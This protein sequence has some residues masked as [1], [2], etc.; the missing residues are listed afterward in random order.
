METLSPAQYRL[1]ERRIAQLTLAMGAAASVGAYLLFSPRVGMGVLIGT[2]LAW[3]SFRWLERALDA[4]VCV[5]TARAESPGARLLLGSIFRLF[6]RYVLIAAVVYVSF[7]LFNIPVLS[8]LVGLCVLGV[9]TIG[10]SLYEI[11]RPSG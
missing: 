10:A 2:V 1:T 4:L 7:T 8:M 9:A 6:G 3:L 5:S 11:L